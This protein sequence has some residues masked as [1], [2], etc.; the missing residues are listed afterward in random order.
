MGGSSALSQVSEAHAV[1]SSALG[2]SPSLQLSSSEE[3]DV[4]NGGLGEEDSPPLF[5]A[6]VTGGGDNSLGV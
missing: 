3:Q 2:E 5:P 6:Y 1:A 4:L